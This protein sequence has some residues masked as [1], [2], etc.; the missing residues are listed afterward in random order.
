MESGFSIKQFILFIFYKDTELYDLRA[1]SIIKH[2]CAREVTI[3]VPV[4]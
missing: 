2:P 3:D 4:L 1:F